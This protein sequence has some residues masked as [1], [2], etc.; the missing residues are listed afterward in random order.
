MSEKETEIVDENA[1]PKQ[2][3]IIDANNQNEAHFKFNENFKL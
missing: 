1:I 3:A 2:H